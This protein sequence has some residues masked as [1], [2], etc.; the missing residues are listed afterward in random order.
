MYAVNHQPDAL[1]VSGLMAGYPALDLKR[2]EEF[3]EKTPYEQPT[4][5]RYNLV[6]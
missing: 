4:S 6:V 2:C 5:V 1:C 3:W